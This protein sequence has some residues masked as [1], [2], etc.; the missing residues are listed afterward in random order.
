MCDKSTKKQ[1][2]EKLICRAVN[3]IKMLLNELEESTIS[4][5]LFNVVYE[6][7]EQLIKL[8]S[9]VEESQD[10]DNRTLSLSQLIEKLW[11]DYCSYLKKRKEVSMFVQLCKEQEAITGENN[12]A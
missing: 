10:A 1:S 11:I 4:I 12:S 8:A 2:A 3:C 9:A 6:N 5:N 7:K